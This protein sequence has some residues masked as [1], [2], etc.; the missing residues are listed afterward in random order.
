MAAALLLLFQLGEGPNAGHEVAS[1]LHAT[2]AGA[3]C[4]T[5]NGGSQRETCAALLLL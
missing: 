4:A 5:V 2:K 1:E 3:A